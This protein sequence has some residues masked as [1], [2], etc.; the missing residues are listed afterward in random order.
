MIS[1]IWPTACCV[2]W[3][4]RNTAQRSIPEN[5]ILVARDLGPADLLEYD[6]TRLKGILLE[7]GS[8]SNHAA[9]VARALQIPCVGR[10]SGLRDRVSQGDPVIVDGETG[11]AYLRPRPDII[12]AASARM[13]VR[14]LRRRNSPAS[15][16]CRR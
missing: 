13:D 5:S 9:I 15:R 12:E 3:P 16:T 6:R 2:S 7:E 10:L 4:A 1:K 8:S 14:A 11:E